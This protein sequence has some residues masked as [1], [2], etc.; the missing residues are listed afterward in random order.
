[1]GFTKLLDYGTDP[2]ASNMIKGL[3]CA[4]SLLISGCDIHEVAHRFNASSVMTKTGELRFGFVETSYFEK[5]SVLRGNPYEIKVNL[6]FDKFSRDGEFID[7]L[8]IHLSYKLFHDN[9]MVFEKQIEVKDPKQIVLGNVKLIDE[10]LTLEY[11]NHRIEAEL[12]VF[13]SSG[14]EIESIT[15]SVPV[16]YT[17]SEHSGPPLP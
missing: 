7:A 10:P 1:M 9:E 4:A 3:V 5:Y 11:A 8:E 12:K 13:D 6:Y 2:F 16:K 15:A 14:T 17:Y